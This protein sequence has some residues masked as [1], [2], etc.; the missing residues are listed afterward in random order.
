MKLNYLNLKK[1]YFLKKK[2]IG[3]SETISYFQQYLIDDLEIIDGT[4][5]LLSHNNNNDIK[6]KIF[7]SFDGNEIIDY[8]NE[9]IKLSTQDRQIF[10]NIFIKKSSYYNYNYHIC[11][12][13]KIIFYNIQLL[14]KFIDSFMWFYRPQIMDRYEFENFLLNLPCSWSHERPETEKI[15]I[16]L[17]FGSVDMCMENDYFNPDYIQIEKL[18]DT[19]PHIYNAYKNFIADNN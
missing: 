18:K 10:I 6:C 5:T 15:L 9:F 17:L 3:G 16:S 14:S 1:N 19:Y 11:P 2:L 8:D 13:N 12:N 7:L 4:F